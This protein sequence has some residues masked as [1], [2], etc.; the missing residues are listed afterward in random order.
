MPLLKRGRS[1]LKPRRRN[2]VFD[3]GVRDIKIR[4]NTV[5]L[6]SS[7]ALQ[8]CNTRFLSRSATRLGTQF[9]RHQ[10]QFWRVRASAASSSLTDGYWRQRSVIEWQA[11]NIR[12]F[13]VL[14]V[15]TH[16]GLCCSDVIVTRFSE[17]MKKRPP[18]I[19]S[20]PIGRAYMAWI[21]EHR[22]HC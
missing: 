3:G 16:F 15:V 14:R 1:S 10:R 11:G 20:K 5:P 2:P 17:V 8:Y 4:N 18:R 21:M 12:S 19:C 7:I 9:P 13:R 6:I 22:N